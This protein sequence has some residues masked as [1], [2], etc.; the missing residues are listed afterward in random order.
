MHGDRLGLLKKAVFPWSNVT[1]TCFITR[2]TAAT[3]MPE[4][5]WSSAHL[6]SCRIFWQHKLW[7]RLS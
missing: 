4:I 6:H 1:A 5:D 3:I 7:W 2:F